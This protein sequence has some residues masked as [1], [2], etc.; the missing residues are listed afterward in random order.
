MI[1]YST[2]IKLH[3]DHA[4]ICTICGAGLDMH[5][6][7]IIADASIF[8]LPKHNELYLVHL[9]EAALSAVPDLYEHSH[10]FLNYLTVILMNEIS[11]VQIPQLLNQKMNELWILM[12]LGPLQS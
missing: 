5:V 8:G 2:Y 10:Q 9:R 1:V 4:I 7:I 11:L 12:K 6:Q 3:A